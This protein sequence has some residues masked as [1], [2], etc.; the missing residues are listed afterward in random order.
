M[1]ALE[2]ESEVF[3]AHLRSLLHFV[4]RE[5]LGGLLEA[6]LRD[7]ATAVPPDQ[8]DLL[9]KAWLVRR[10]AAD[11]LERTCTLH[12]EFFTR[13]LRGSVAR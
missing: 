9:K 6:V 3:A 7:P 1:L 2:P 8:E 10:T 12:R 4:E 13:V 5:S 11:R